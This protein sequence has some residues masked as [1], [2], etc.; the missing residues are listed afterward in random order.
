MEALNLIALAAATLGGRAPEFLG[1]A[2]DKVRRGIH[3]HEPL[4]SHPGMRETFELLAAG[5]S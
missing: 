5:R 2:Q 1:R 4:L 3:V